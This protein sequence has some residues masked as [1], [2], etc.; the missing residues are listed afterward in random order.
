MQVDDEQAEDAAR[1][2]GQPDGRHLELSVTKVTVHIDY[3]DVVRG[4]DRL[5]STPGDNM[6]Q[7]A[8]LDTWEHPPI[9]S[10]MSLS[11]S[12]MTKTCWET[13]GTSICEMYAQVTKMLF[14]SSVGSIDYYRPRAQSVL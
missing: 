10:P 7:V 8:A 14:V 2:V 6:A 13:L 11:H 3:W 12:R 5:L 4:G 1:H 9:S